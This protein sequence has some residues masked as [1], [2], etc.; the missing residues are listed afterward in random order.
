MLYFVNTLG[1]AFASAASVM[2]ILGK[3]GQSGSVRIAAMLNVTVSLL[4]Y[5]A[6]RRAARPK[7]IAETLAAAIAPNE[8]S[9]EDQ[10]E[11]QAV[12]T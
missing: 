11:D 1:S 7:E 4:A 12:R 8:S 9:D 5:V 2:F 3:A 10:R 6:H